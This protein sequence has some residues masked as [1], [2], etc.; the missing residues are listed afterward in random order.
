[1]CVEGNTRKLPTRLN[2][3]RKGVLI[4]SNLCMLCKKVEETVQHVLIN[5][6]VTQKVWQN[7]DG[8]I[9][10]SYVRHYKIVKHFQHFYLA[11]FNKKIN[12]VWKRMWVA[13]PT[14]SLFL[15]YV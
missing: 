11:C 7:C 4:V 13:S 14:Q 12:T 6:E 3:E 9:G 15:D 1:M 2:L 10:I 5:C 8:W